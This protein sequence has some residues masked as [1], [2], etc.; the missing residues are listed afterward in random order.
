MPVPSED[1]TNDVTAAISQEFDSNNCNAMAS[2]TSNSFRSFP[3]TMAQDMPLHSEV[4]SFRK[5][6]FCSISIH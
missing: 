1:N 2:H 4:M 5:V 3:S 6:A